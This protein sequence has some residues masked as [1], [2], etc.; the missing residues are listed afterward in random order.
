VSHPNLNLPTKARS[1]RTFWNRTVR[2]CW[3]QPLRSSRLRQATAPTR[4]RRVV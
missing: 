1:S 4:L 3:S 2:P